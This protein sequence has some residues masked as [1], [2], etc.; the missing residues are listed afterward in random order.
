[1]S[2]Y[3]RIL[4]NVLY[5]QGMDEKIDKVRHFFRTGKECRR[6]KIRLF[7]STFN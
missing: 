2:K 6:H 1:M 4:L 3:T 5:N 7:F